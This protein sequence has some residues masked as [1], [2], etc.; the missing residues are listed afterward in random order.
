MNNTLTSGRLF[1]LKISLGTFQQFEETIFSLVAEKRPA[2]VCVANV[3]MFMEGQDN[4]TLAACMNSAEL[5][6]PDGKPLC[7]ALR[8]ISG[9]RQERVAGMDL[10]PSLL[11]AAAQN[12]TGVFFYG[13]TPEM[14]QRTEN[15]IKQN[16]PGLVIS[17]MYSP[18]FRPLSP[19]EEEGIAQQITASRAGIVFVVLG[20]PKQELWMFRMR[21][22][23]P[24]VMIGVGGALP[25]LTGMQKRAPQWMQH[26][27]L[28][29]FYRLMQEPRRL[30]KRYFY[31]N[32]RFLYKLLIALLF[33]KS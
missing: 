25:V 24:A 12:H 21:D 31:T 3:H 5:V 26:S 27:G 9:I 22:R 10:L 30:F 2:V 33:R 8:L 7:W 19:E 4:K 13:G 17:G 28:E 32:S 20:C 29:W 18:P 1:G 6:T 23:I 16:M 15:Y 14:L 11:S